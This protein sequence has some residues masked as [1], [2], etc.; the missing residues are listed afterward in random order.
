MSSKTH[1]EVR[2]AADGLRKKDDISLVDILTLA[3][4]SI[5]SMKSFIDNLDSKIYSEFR[6][7]AVYIQNTKAE[8]GH[9]QANDLRSKHIPEAGH[10]LSAVVSS[11]EEATTKIMECAEA[12]LEADPSDMEAYQQMVNNKVMDIFEA[13]SFQDITGQ[14]ISKVVETLEHIESRVARFAAAIGAKDTEHPASEKE[15]KRNKRKKDQILNGP[16]NEGE[17]VSQDDIDALLSA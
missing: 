5:H 17:G 15:I 8:I 11:T 7:I 9:L 2:L 3:E 1:A 16:A 10:E 14:R 12:I 13:C 6:E 4:A